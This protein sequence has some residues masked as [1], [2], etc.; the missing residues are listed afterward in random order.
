[1]RFKDQT[2]I[3]TG[4]GS[5][6]G[7]QV[8]RDLYVE[9]AT[10]AFLGRSEDKLQ[11]LIAELEAK[12]DGRLLPYSCDVS[13]EKEVHQVFE[14]LKKKGKPV[15]GLVN[16]AAVNPSRNTITNTSAADWEKT[17]QVNLTGA[18]HCTKEAVT[19]MLEGNGGSIVNISSIAGI[20]ALRERSAYCASKFGLVGLTESTA[21][22]YA[23]QDIRVNCIC[24][25]YV[26]TPLVEKFFKGLSS[27]KAEELIQAHPMKRLGTPSDISN[28][29]L[30]LL[31]D[32]ATWITGAVLP[33]DGGYSVGK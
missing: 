25:G 11:K 8:V 6:I 5:G 13:S 29:V 9:G 26:K 16:N 17:L 3:V 7:A 32:E 14:D 24:P 22:D 12:G 19:Q 2:I 28:A 1:M 4:G 30:F 10:V 18:F 21:L 27:V 23:S 15:T 33:V 20:T 31:S